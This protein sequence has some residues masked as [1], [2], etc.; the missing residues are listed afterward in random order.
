[1][2]NSPDPFTAL[3]KLSDFDSIKICAIID[4]MSRLGG[5]FILGAI[6]LRIEDSALPQ[7]KRELYQLVIQRAEKLSLDAT[8]GFGYAWKNWSKTT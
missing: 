4:L 2:E 7:T 1:M 6:K 8:K 3:D 5:V